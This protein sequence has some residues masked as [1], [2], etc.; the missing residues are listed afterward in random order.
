MAV[1]VTN[2]SP[3]LRPNKGY[4]DRIR[5]EIMYF[6]DSGAGM[7]CVLALVQVVSSQRRRSLHFPGHGF[8]FVNGIRFYNWPNAQAGCSEHSWGWYQTI[9]DYDT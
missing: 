5:D 1:F 6:D 2:F 7:F 8:I 4:H 9:T 3:L